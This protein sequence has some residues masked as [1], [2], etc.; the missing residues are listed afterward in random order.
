MA[1]H[2]SL[3]GRRAL[4]TGASSGIGLHV[5]QVLATAGAEVVLAA[6]RFNELEAAA[7]QI[8]IG[9]GRARALVLDIR[10]PS[11]VAEAIAACPPFDILINNAGMVRSGGALDQAEADWDS[12][13]DTNLKGMFFVTQAVARAMREGKRA[14]SIVNVASILGLRQA[15]GVLPYAVSKAGVIQMTKSMAL[16]LA[17][18]DI[19]VNAIAPGYLST[20]LNR[21]FFESPTGQAMIARIPQR[22]LGELED[23]DGPLLLLASDLSRY[24]TGSVLT[25]DGGHLVGS[26]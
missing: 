8:R 4:V 5:A 16:E 17:R 21:E 23:L 2:P 9:G 7:D 15:G 25:V 20:D 19:R 12:V 6:R 13:L 3:Q 10:N 11:A 24:M 18:H 26:L 14:G 1:L 22:R